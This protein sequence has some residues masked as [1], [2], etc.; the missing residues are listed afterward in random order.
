MLRFCFPPLRCITLFL[1]T[2]CTDKHGTRLIDATPVR[3][4]CHAPPRP[5]QPPPASV[6]RFPSLPIF[7]PPV[8][9][10][11]TSDVICKLG[12]ICAR[13]HLAPDVNWRTGR[14]GEIFLKVFVCFTHSFPKHEENRPCCFADRFHSVPPVSDCC[15]SC[16]TQHC[17]DSSLCL[18]IILCDD[19]DWASP[20]DWRKC[21]RLWRRPF[22][23]EFAACD[24]FTAANCLR[25]LTLW[26]R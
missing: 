15:D 8:L 1:Q 5:P 2:C 14:T 21:F 25:A 10:L 12:G 3:R 23:N 7:L 11:V 22:F 17:S 19:Y 9:S 24:G 13:P 16:G 20:S 18:H 26:A 6:V 4:G